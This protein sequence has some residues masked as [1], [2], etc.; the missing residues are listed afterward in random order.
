MKAVINHKFNVSGPVLLFLVLAFLLSLPGCSEKFP[1]SEFET[2]QIFLGSAYDIQVEGSYSYV[3]TNRGLV[4]IDISDPARPEEIV[5]YETDEAAFG[6]LVEAD[7][8]YLGSGQVESLI[9]LDVGDKNNPRLVSSLDIPGTVYDIQKDSAHLYISTVQGV[10][11]IID[12]TEL[13]SPVIAFEL[14][15]SGRVLTWPL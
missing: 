5:T 2:G 11:Y 15:C 9:I 6:I 3:T 14:D 13:T 10:F 1:P 4:I 12:I 7:V 8:A